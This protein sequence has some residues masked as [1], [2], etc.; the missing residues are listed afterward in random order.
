VS[1][2]IAD[3]RVDDM[4]DALRGLIRARDR[5]KILEQELAVAD[6][7]IDAAAEAIY[8]ATL[9]DPEGVRDDAS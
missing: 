9:Y 2:T 1:L 3:R 6:A 7:A 8:N 5:R 4:Q